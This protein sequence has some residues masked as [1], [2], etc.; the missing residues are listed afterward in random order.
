M[1]RDYEI[2][3]DTGNNGLMKLSDFAIKINI[4]WQ[5]KQDNIY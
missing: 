2:P 4:Y 1:F 3:A 5:I